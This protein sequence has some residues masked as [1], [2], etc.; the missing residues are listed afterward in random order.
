VGGPVLVVPVDAGVTFFPPAPTRALADIPE[1]VVS[2]PALDD[3]FR[4]PR[5]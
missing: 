4:P 5:V 2:N 3:I 1:T